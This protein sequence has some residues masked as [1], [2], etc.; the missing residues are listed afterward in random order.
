MDVWAYGPLEP[1]SERR[2]ETR[3]D[4]DDGRVRLS[5]Y[6]FVAESRAAS[7]SCEPDGKLKFVDETCS[8]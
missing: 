8:N 2:Y 3:V 6:S 1:F 4:T 7:S 5:R